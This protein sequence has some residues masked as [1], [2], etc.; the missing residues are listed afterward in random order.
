[1]KRARCGKKIVNSGAVVEYGSLFILPRMLARRVTVAGL[2]RLVPDHS[3]ATR[4]EDPNVLCRA[5]FFEGT[6]W[7]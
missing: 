5:S 3:S 4:H 7:I 1:L 2:P 6:P